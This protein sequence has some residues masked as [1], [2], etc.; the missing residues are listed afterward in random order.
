MVAPWF[1]G[2]ETDELSAG[3]VNKQSIHVQDA[4]GLPFW[5]VELRQSAKILRSDWFW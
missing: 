5:K 4:G 3:E 2:L 1:R